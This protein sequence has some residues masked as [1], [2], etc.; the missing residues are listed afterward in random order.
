MAELWYIMIQ[1]AMDLKDK[2]TICTVKI[3]FGLN[4]KGTIPRGFKNCPLY[5]HRI[6]F[7]YK[8]K[9]PETFVIRS[10]YLSAF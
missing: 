10:F 8:S 7:E 6:A 1:V 9:L 5:V 2:H 3:L 4:A